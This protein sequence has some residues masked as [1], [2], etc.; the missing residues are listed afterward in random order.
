APPGGGG[1][2]K[3]DQANV[4]YG[5]TITFTSTVPKLKGNENA[6]VAVTCAQ[7]GKTLWTDI[8][9]PNHSFTLGGPFQ[10]S[11]WVGGAA[12]CRAEIDIYGH[13]AIQVLDAVLFDVAA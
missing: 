5:D 1:T 3:L 2:I 13:A 8:W 4:H 10:S 6:L 7:D 9:P 12:D 11:N